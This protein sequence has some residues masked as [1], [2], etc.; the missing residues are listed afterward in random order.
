VRVV[1]A[2][3]LCTTTFAAVLAST[4]VIGAPAASATVPTEI[5]HDTVG[6]VPNP[7]GDIVTAGAGTDASGY[8]FSVHV[9][10][11][12][13]PRS[14][15]NWKSNPTHA[16]WDLDTNLDGNPDAFAT[17]YA[18][19]AG[20]L[21]ATMERSSD[22]FVY[23]TGVGR[24]SAANDY[25]A[26]FPAG[27]IPGVVHFRWSAI[28]DYDNGSPQNDVAPDLS[29]SQVHVLGKVG[30]W[31]LGLDARVYNFGSS[32]AAPRPATF[33]LA[34]TPKLD[35]SGYWIV[36][37]AGRVFPRGTAKKYGAAPGLSRGE[38]VTTIS[39]TP[40][41][42]GY[43]VFSSRGRV[44]AYGDA[45]NYGGLGTTHLNRPI[46]ASVATPTGRG[47]YMV[48]R[49]GGVF[50]FGDAR[51]HG[52]TGDMHLNQPVVGIAPTPDNAGYWLVASDGGVFSFGDAPFRGS[53]GGTRLNRPVNGLVAYGNGYLMVA[54]DG[55]VFDFSNRAFLGSLAGRTLSA[56]IVGIAAFTT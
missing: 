51:F 26:T 24:Y 53:M 12:V 45:H 17:L 33:A 47:Y 3:V 2:V 48:A 5:I 38:I 31:M 19:S 52:S 56:P 13:D 50:S 55:G 49:D 25:V 41:G 40:T 16:E 34:I 44:F 23:C 21:H 36:D 7:R 10:T 18:D 1:A 22:Q 15:V 6:D 43:W 32:F 14:D 29:F 20:N 27:C 8:A 9:R 37:P 46:I 30:Y 4:F 28:M 39:A 54:A 42:L 11:P 35:G